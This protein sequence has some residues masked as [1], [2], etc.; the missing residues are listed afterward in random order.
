MDIT[1]VWTHPITQLDPNITGKKPICC[2][3]K[4]LNSLCPATWIIPRQI[5]VDTDRM[6][7]SEGRLSCQAEQPVLPWSLLLLS[8]YLTNQ[9][10]PLAT[11]RVMYGR[12]MTS[13]YFRDKEKKDTGKEGRISR[14][15]WEEGMVTHS[16]RGRAAAL[17][18]RAA[19]QGAEK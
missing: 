4:Q 9:K 6:L 1:L 16:K 15:R 3:S 12:L 7:V 11:D 18:T 17:T 19:T 8:E 13:R 10:S 14:L 5:L 2:S